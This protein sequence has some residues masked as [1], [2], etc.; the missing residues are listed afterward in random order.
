MT[1]IDS[2]RFGHRKSSNVV[3]LM[4]YT[5]VYRIFT[6]KNSIKNFVRWNFFFFYRCPSVAD[7]GVYRWETTGF[8]N[9]TLGIRDPTE[10]EPPD[11]CEPMQPTQEKQV[12]NLQSVKETFEVFSNYTKLADVA[13]WYCF[14]VKIKINSVKN[15]PLIG[16]E[17]ATLGLWHSLCLHSH[18]LTIVLTH[19][20]L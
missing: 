9:V 11:D 19:H 5:Y 20:C 7:E 1:L 6:V 13:F 4:T 3:I 18:A 14:V 8:M 10:L 12:G 15:L 2:D 17:S 16:I